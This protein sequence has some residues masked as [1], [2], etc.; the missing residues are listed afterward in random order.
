MD[1]VFDRFAGAKFFS[2]LDLKSGFWQ[3]PV[4]E[5]DR[6]KTAFVTPD[7]LYEFLRLPYFCG[8]RDRSGGQVAHNDK[9]RLFNAALGV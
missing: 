8:M 2:S 7:G 6:S 5:A 9:V 1:D 3:V 4:A